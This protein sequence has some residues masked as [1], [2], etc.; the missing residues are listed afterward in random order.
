MINICQIIKKD[1]LKSKLLI[2][3]ILTL[4]RS[5]FQNQSQKNTMEVKLAYN[6]KEKHYLLNVKDIHPSV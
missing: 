3:L 5:L 6:I 4:Q 2:F 1:K